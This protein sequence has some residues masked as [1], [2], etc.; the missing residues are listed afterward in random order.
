MN[1]VQNSKTTL[2]SAFGQN[3][4]RNN[5][6]RNN[7]DHLVKNRALL[8]YR[9]GLFGQVAILEFFKTGNPMNLVQN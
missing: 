8:D 2:C 1:L 5:I 9:K 7:N 3:T 4:L 6:L